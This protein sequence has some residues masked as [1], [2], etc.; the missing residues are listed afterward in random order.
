MSS[1]DLLI[2]EKTSAAGKVET[3]T[4]NIACHWIYLEI[5]VYEKEDILLFCSLFQSA[6]LEK[7]ID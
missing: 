7:L 6:F 3:S 1:W 5:E 4:V 2:P